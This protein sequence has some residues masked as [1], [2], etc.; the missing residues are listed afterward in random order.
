[1]NLGSFYLS[2]LS[3]LRILREELQSLNDDVADCLDRSSDRFSEKVLEFGHALAD[4][5]QIG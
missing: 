4:G 2:L 5:I 3:S 1:M